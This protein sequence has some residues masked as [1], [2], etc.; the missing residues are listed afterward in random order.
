MSYIQF[1]RDLS[2]SVISFLKIYTACLT[3]IENAE[4]SH[5]DKPYTFILASDIKSSKGR[6]VTLYLNFFIP[7]Y[8]SLIHI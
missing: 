7:Q 8:L 1:F 2:Y 3:P 6:F 5:P 4:S